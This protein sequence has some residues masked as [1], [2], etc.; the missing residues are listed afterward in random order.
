MSGTKQRQKDARLCRLQNADHRDGGAENVRSV[1]IGGGWL[2]MT[3]TGTEKVAEFIVASTEPGRRPSTLEPAH[4]LISSFDAT[5]ILIQPVVET[6]ARAMAHVSAQFSSDR[7][8]IAV[9]PV[10]RDADRGDAVDWVRFNEP[11][12]RSLNCLAHA[13]QRNRR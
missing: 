11:P 3:R 1:V 8:R 7:P 6:T 5:V 12:L 2:V 13:R 9:V 4:R 10:G